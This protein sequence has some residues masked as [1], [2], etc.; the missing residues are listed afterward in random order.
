[1]KLPKQIAP[2]KTTWNK[3]KICT[4]LE[5]HIK[6]LVL[7]AV[8]NTFIEEL[9]NTLM[10]FA[11][12][13]T[14]QILS[15]LRT[16][17]GT[18]TPN[19]LKINL[20][21]QWNPGQPLEDLWKQINTCQKFA[22]NSAK[23]I[24]NATVICL[25]LDNLEESGVFHHKIQDWRK[26]PIANHT[27]PNL[28]TNFNAANIAQI[29]LCSSKSAGYTQLANIT[30]IANNATAKLNAPQ[31]PFSAPNT[32]PQ[33]CWSHGLVALPHENPHNS[34]TCRTR[35]PGH[36]KEARLLNMMGGCNLICGSRTHMIWRQPADKLTPCCHCPTSCRH[37]N[38]TT[39]DAFA[40]FHHC[41][42]SL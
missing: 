15:H 9:A 40:R 35:L 23:T 27:L 6:K 5:A 8:P 4:V 38:L 2:T 42:T 19:N 26:L 17:Y 16:V 28:K 11:G 1:M 10:G 32:S 30:N 25:T 36:C 39:R 7:N 24:T 33:Y 37:P 21:R 14:I 13:S 31:P 20:S 34:K 3:F 12:V 41:P 29:C 18:V 22:V